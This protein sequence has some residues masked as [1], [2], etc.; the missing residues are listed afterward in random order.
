VPDCAASLHLSHCGIVTPRTGG[1]LWRT[2]LLSMTIT[3]R[4]INLALLVIVISAN[5]AFPDTVSVIVDIHRD[6]C[7]DISTAHLARAGDQ[8][9]RVC[10]L[11]GVH[12]ACRTRGTSVTFEEPG[13]QPLHVVLLCGQVAQRKIRMDAVGPKGL[14][15]ALREAAR[16]YIYAERVFDVALR[17]G[18]DFALV[19]GRVAAHEVGHLILPP[20][21]HSYGGIMRA[22]LYF[23]RTFPETFPAAE[24][25]AILEV[26]KRAMADSHD[27]DHVAS[28]RP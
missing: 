25:R 4:G 24:S 9:A 21:S 18:Y 8:A 15:E 1:T 16:A 7:P 11:A 17:N 13:S 28:S 23:R 19:L 3:A 27:E 14:G 5:Q 20:H 22:D 12:L 2:R 26:L 10:A 6:S